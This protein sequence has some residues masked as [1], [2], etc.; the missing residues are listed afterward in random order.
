MSE[1]LYNRYHLNCGDERRELFFL[2]RDEYKCRTGLYPGCFVLI[3]PSFYI[4]GMIYVDSD[5]K[6][7]RFFTS[8]AASLMVQKEKIY[9][10]D[11]LM[12]FYYQD[13]RAFIPIAFESADLLIS[14]YA[15]YVSDYCSRYLKKGGIL[16]VNNSHGDAGLAKADPGFNFIGVLRQ[17]MS[18]VDKKRFI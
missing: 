8:R 6:A 17:K 3:T 14:Q 2:L 16:L 1:D 13:Y 10:E 5:L 11:S 9:K 12:N 4:P 15:G 7:K 18:Q